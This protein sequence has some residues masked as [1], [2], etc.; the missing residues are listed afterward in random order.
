MW[1]DSFHDFKNDRIKE[2][3][4]D[5]A[6]SKGGYNLNNIVKKLTGKNIDEYYRVYVYIFKSGLR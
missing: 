5:E 3:S 1:F 6:E 4:E 2:K